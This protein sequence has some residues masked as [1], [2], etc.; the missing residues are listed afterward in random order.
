MWCG[1]RG[2]HR[3]LVGDARDEAAFV[4]LMMGEVAE[5]GIHDP[6]YNVR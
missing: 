4:Q 3:L 2:R 6:P 5:M 1:A